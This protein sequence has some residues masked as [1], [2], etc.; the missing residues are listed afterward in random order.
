MPQNLSAQIVCPIPKVWDFDEKRLHC[1]YSPKLQ[2]FLLTN[3]VVIFIK[4]V[5]LVTRIVTWNITKCRKTP[6]LSSDLIQDSK[7]L[8]FNYLLWSNPRETFYPQDNKGENFYI[9]K[10]LTIFVTVYFTKCSHRFAYFLNT[11]ILC[12][13]NG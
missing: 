2:T 11:L 5:C 12:I 6:P 7:N 10:P 13:S 4:T 3:A 1:P 9:H 8:E